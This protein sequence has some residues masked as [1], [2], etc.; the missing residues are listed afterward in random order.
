[1]PFAKLLSL[2]A[3]MG[4]AT[5]ARADFV[6]PRS[7]ENVAQTPGE[8]TTGFYGIS[9][10]IRLYQYAA[11]ELSAQGL[12][13][14]DLITGVRGRAASF[15][16]GAATSPTSDMTWTDFTIQLAQAT[17]SIANMSPFASDD[18]TNPVTVRSGPFTLPANSM[19]SGTNNTT[20]GS[21]M[22]FS[23]PYVYQ[24]GDLVFY[25]SR[26]EGLGP[27]FPQDSPAMYTGA[28]TLYRSVL[29]NPGFTHGSFLNL[30]T[31]LK[32][33]TTAVP[34]PTA[35]ASTLLVTLA[36]VGSRRRRP[37]V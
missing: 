1:M 33:E 29:F 17:N 8:G 9:P 19:P 25:F 18:M 27:S 14:G 24:G 13:P 2:I 16:T 23:T 15:G 4:C 10:E 36:S 28:G 3:I 32:F 22:S 12:K 35:G 30:M 20:F 21:L 31:A 11:S 37:V 26:G 6:T 5:L 7:V 34:E